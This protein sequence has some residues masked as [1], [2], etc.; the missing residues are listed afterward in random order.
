V[1]SDD[2]SDEY[3]DRTKVAPRTTA[4]VIQVDTEESYSSLKS[5]L[6]ALVKERQNLTVEMRNA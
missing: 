3:F 6:E 5:K 1:D 4:A 2:E